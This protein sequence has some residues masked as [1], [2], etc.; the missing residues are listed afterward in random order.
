[1][2]FIA[3]ITQHEIFPQTLM[4]CNFLQMHAS[5]INHEQIMCKYMRFIRRLTLV[6]IAANYDSY[7]KKNLF[8]FVQAIVIPGTVSQ[9]TIST[10]M[11]KIGCQPTWSIAEWW[12]AIHTFLYINLCSLW[13]HCL[14]SISALEITWSVARKHMLGWCTPD[15]FSKFIKVQ[16]DYTPKWY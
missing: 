12:K 1:M 8:Y 11:R 16:K 5:M 2:N 9:N 4:F 6:I 13:Q 15:L 14:P 3:E 10:V 7:Y